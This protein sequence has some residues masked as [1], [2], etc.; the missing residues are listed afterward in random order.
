MNKHDLTYSKYAIPHAKHVLSDIYPQ[1]IGFSV[2][3]QEKRENK[4]NVAFVKK[5]TYQNNK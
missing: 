4:E 2:T 5:K 3:Y 1:W